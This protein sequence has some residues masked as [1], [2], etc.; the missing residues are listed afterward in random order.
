MEGRFFS[1]QFGTEIGRIG[2]AAPE[3]ESHK[4]NLPCYYYEKIAWCRPH[5][6]KFSVCIKKVEVIKHGRSIFF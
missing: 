1:A 2:A 6:R 3:L 4:V 5:F